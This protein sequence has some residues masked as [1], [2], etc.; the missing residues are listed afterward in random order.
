MDVQKVKVN[1][2]V[3]GVYAKSCLR[4]VVSELTEIGRQLT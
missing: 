3:G 4:N 1:E 2:T